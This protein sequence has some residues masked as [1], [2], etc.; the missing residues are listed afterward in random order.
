MAKEKLV[1]ICQSGG[2]F[3]TGTDG[4]LSY[5]GGD[6][7][8]MT[9][10]N[11]TRF[12][13]FESE[14]AEIWK[15]DSSSM[16][17]KYFLPNNKQTL[18][19]VS[20][21]RDI[22][23]M[24]EFHEDSPTVDVYVMITQIAATN[25]ATTP[26]SRSSRTTGV[27]AIESVSPIIALPDFVAD[28][29]DTGKHIITS[30][31]KNIITGLDQ[32][33]N[34]VSDFRDAL[35]TYSVAHGF[36][37]TLK[38]N[39]SK[40]VNVKCR[41]EGCPWHIIATRLST[42]RLF[43]IK[44]MNGTH[45]CEVGTTVS[46]PHAS[47]K[48]LAS[49]VK[50]KLQ[51]SPNYR[52]REIIDEIRHDFG[53][54]LAYKQAWRGI[55]TAREELQGSYKEAY[56]QLPWLCEKILE[57][58]PGSVATLITKDDMSFHRIFVAL[59]ALLHGFQNGCRPLLFLD[60]MPLKSK[61][62]EEMLIATALDG[63]DGVFPVAFAIMDVRS[64][65]NWHW[66]LVQLQAVLSTCQSITFVADRKKGISDSIHLL[67]ENCYHGYCLHHLTES[68]K[69]ELKRPV[70]QEAVRVIVAEFYN[71]AYAPTLDGFKKCIE[72]IKKVSHEAYEWVLQSDP[73]HWANAFFKGARYNH[74]KS[75]IAESF[76]S[77]VSEQPPLPVTQVIETL[78]EKMM[79]LIHKRRVGSD[80]WS[81]RL[82][83][84]LEEKLQ[85]NT[86]SSHL[87][88]VLLS[89][90][91]SM[92]EVRDTTGQVNAVN[93]QLW[94]CSCREWQITGLPCLHAEVVI[95]YFGKN[96]HDF[97]SKYFTVET[98][99]HAYSVSINP[100][101]TASDRSILHPESLP[102]H[103][104]PPSVRRPIGRP[105]EKWNQPKGVV[106]RPFICSKCKKPGHNRLRCKN[107]S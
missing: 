62:Q 2:K 16:S 26:C 105:K 59:H 98:F 11:E 61:Y 78:C 50:E 15:C 58:N 89:T 95:K 27:T 88:E 6:A 71:A 1:I 18:I 8:V 49:I 31:W 67:F 74:V 53:I 37:Y 55:E 23:H 57:T 38:E 51:H 42:T 99:R 66:F 28:A 73:E 13:E 87:F 32:R 14:V 10:N 85:R 97:C 34:S 56:N 80:Y 45:T 33:F 96:A 86:I 43:R 90:G 68:L 4:S 52:P 101:P 106:R 22:K 107:L 20:S 72:T 82:T 104:H 5:S 77:W 40:R 103:V 81:S 91:S 44:K 70:T 65:D 60:N 12:D 63:D 41:A 9:I 3:T 75:N 84:S 48:L 24:I 83:P 30:S 19:T 64:D 79:E 39:S 29:E 100:V 54:E 21:D 7:H 35:N 69:V 25:P 17:I 92:Y 93:L 94:S 76:Y 47:Q 46:R 102:S 36:L